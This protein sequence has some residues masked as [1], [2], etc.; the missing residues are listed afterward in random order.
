MKRTIQP[1]RRLTLEVGVKKFRSAKAEQDAGEQIGSGADQEIT[2]AGS[3]RAEWAEKILRRMVRRRSEVKEREPGRNVLRERRRSGQERAASRFREGSGRRLHSRHFAECVWPP[4][5]IVVAP[6][7]AFNSS[8][9]TRSRQGE[10]GRTGSSETA[11][12]RPV[13]GVSFRFVIIYR[14]TMTPNS[15]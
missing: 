10:I 11:R 14:K 15:S 9:S 6:P 2:N 1:S 13:L 4:R 3:N 5:L 7:A 12:P 8:L